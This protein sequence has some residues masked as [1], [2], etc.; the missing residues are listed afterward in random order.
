MDKNSS[1]AKASQTAGPLSEHEKYQLRR[2]L[3][4]ADLTEE[5]AKA[6]LARERIAEAKAEQQRA[7][8]E[9]L[10]AELAQLRSNIDATVE[11]LAGWNVSKRHVAGRFE[12]LFKL[13]ETRPYLRV[14]DAESLQLLGEVGI[15]FYQNAGRPRGVPLRQQQQEG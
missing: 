13:A 8:E 4:R 1:H 3:G 9:K 12:K 15:S 2:L 11:Q 5:Q 10:A 7:E 14:L 6:E